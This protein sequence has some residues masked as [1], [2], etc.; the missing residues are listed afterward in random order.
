MTSAIRIGL[1]VSMI[2]LGSLPVRAEAIEGRSV[3]IG[4]DFGALGTWW[5]RS[6]AG[7][8]ARV[9]VPVS[10]RH[11]IETFV[12]VA[13]PSSGETLGFYGVMVKQ[14]LRST[15]TS[16]PRP[17]LS[18]G[19]AG[20]V[21]VDGNNSIVTPPFAGVVGGGVEQRIHDLA[22]VRVE[23]QAL[24]LLVIPVAVRVMTGVSVP[25]GRSSR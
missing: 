9:G 1:V 3:Q 22:I 23:A 14:R 8:D 19:A 16:G 21:Y 18:F 17:F 4:G 11:D 24:T 13:K 7:A 10:E 6:F 2:V 12:G 5:T 15:R 25:I 20:I